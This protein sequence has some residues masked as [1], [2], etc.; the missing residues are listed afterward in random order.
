LIT[1]RIPINEQV[2]FLLGGDGND[3]LMGECGNDKLYGGLG[4]DV[5]DG[6]P[7]NDLLSDG[8]KSN[9]FCRWKWRGI[10]T[11]AP[12]CVGD[13]DQLMDDLAIQCYI[14]AGYT[15]YGHGFMESSLCWIDNFIDDLGKGRN[16]KP[17]YCF[18]T[19]QPQNNQNNGNS[20][21]GNAYGH[22]K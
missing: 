4:N 9:P 20:G 16:N 8:E 5:L 21:N 17:D 2:R 3:I 7:G 18:K 22:G 11:L 10:E 12:K 1:R 13:V 15:G 14:L 6:G 19:N